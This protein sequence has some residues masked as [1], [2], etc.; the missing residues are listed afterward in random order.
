M[1]KSSV[2]RALAKAGNLKLIDHRLSTS[3]PTDFSGLPGFENGSAKF[4]NFDELFPT[5]DMEIPKGYAGWLLFLDEFA[6]ASRSTMAAAYKTILDKM[7]GQKRLHKDVYIVMASNKST[8]NAIVNPIGTAMQ[9]RVITLDLELDFDIWM[10]DV[11]IKQ[12]YHPMIRAFLASNKS[13]LMDFRPDHTEKTFCCP[14]TWEFMNEQ[15]KATNGPVDFMTPAYTGTISSGVATEFV[16]FCKVFDQ[17]I[18]LH[19]V[20]T[21]PHQCRIPMDSASQWAMVCQLSDAANADI[22]EALA[23]YTSR[24][25]LDFRIL[26][27]RTVMLRLPELR[28]TPAFQKACMDV[29]QYL[30]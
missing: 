28:Y 21:N 23:I 24:F 4:M 6:S 25:S 19:D 27:F 14:R 20:V 30:K 16:Q 1:G 13:K 8:D 9:S 29:A 3:D 17:L 5:E 22:F 26:F 11:A 2:V 15:I 12:G 7:V 18:P 10:E